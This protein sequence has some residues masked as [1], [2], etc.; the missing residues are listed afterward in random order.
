[1]NTNPSTRRALLPLLLAALSLAAPLPADEIAADPPIR[2]WK[3]NLHTHSLWSDGNDFPEMIAEWYRTHGYNFLAISDHNVLAEG[4]RWMPQDAVAKRSGEQALAKYLARFGAT[5]VE[6]RTTPEG[7]AEVRLKPFSEYCPLVEEAGV[8]L[9]IPSEEISDSAER[10]PVHLNATNLEKVIAPVGGSTVR[11]AIENNVRA[12]EEQAKQTGREIII[13]L[14]HPNF[15]FAITAEDL[16]EVLSERFFEVYNGHPGVHQL[17]DAK[18]PSVERLWDVANTI[19]VAQLNAPPL[20]GIA[21]DDSH[22]YHDMPASARPGRGW[23]MVRATHLT[24]ESLI[25]SLR[26]GDM[27][28]SSGV[29]LADVRFDPAAGLLELDIQPDGDATFKTQFIGTMADYDAT[30]QPPPT[31]GDKPIRASRQYSA[32]VGRVLAEV[33]GPHP[34]YRLT[35]GELYVRAVVTS[36]RPHVDPSFD[37]QQQQAWTQPVGWEGRVKAP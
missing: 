24:P 27:Y 2:W 20:W 36:S 15:G 33:E 30:S 11:E 37:G 12:V 21:T 22:D 28:A 13:H 25:R 8:F 7:A 6:T 26:K 3:G 10:V 19:R 1:M 17:G 16:A 5:W 4:T 35:G 14:N 23:T 9:M 31:D 32:D 18:H 34:A 29:T